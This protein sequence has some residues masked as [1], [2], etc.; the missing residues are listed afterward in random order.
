MGDVSFDRSDMTKE[1]VKNQ[2]YEDKYVAWCLTSY[3]KELLK[4]VAN[5]KT[6]PRYPDEEDNA[7]IN[8]ANT[9]RMFEWAINYYEQ[10]KE[11]TDFD[12]FNDRYNE[13]CK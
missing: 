9:K 4:Q 6:S 11:I 3:D 7:I 12:E 5:I 13:L 10:L 8:T 2:E 1:E